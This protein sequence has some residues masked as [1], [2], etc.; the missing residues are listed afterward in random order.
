VVKGATEVAKNPLH[1]G[2]VQLPYG[3]HVKAHLLDNVGNVG[4]VKMR[5]WRASVGHHI[6]DW[7][8]VVIGYLLL[9]VDR[10][11]ARF[12]IG[13]ANPLQDVKSVPSLVKEEALRAALHGD[14]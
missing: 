6:V 5:Y 13:H 9:G 14:P 3:M 11:V 10:R 1:G 12:A 2:E 4:R 8:V 7:D